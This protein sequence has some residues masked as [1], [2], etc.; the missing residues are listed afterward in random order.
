MHT[1]SF[2]VHTHLKIPEPNSIAP[3][4]V[5]AGVP[6][7]AEK[8]R[9]GDSESV[10]PFSHIVV[11][12]YVLIDIYVHTIMLRYLCLQHLMRRAWCH[13]NRRIMPDGRRMFCLYEEA[14]EG[15]QWEAEETV[16]GGFN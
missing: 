7:R 5:N 16:V 9:R 2:Q 4:T 12:G 15:S 1:T 11:T 3:G 8:A 13:L 10:S 14:V 6:T